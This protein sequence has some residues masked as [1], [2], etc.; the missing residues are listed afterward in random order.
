[1]KAIIFLFLVVNGAWVLMAFLL[2]QAGVRPTVVAP[3]VTIGVLLGNLTTYGGVK[4]AGKML[5]KTE[6]GRSTR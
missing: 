6:V 1:M 4:L 5:R 2:Y 3:V